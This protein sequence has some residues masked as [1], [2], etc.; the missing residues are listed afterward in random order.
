MPVE[1]EQLKAR[2]LSIANSNSE[3]QMTMP[4]HCACL[5]GMV[6][7]ASATSWM[8]ACDPVGRWRMVVQMVSK[9]PHVHG[10]SDDIMS[11]LMAWMPSLF[12]YG[13][14]KF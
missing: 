7:Y 14:E 13:A 5:M 6:L 1:D 9:V 8:A 3:M 2:H 4:G 10:K 12:V 11:A